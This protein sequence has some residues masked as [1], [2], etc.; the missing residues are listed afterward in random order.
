VLIWGDDPKTR[1][2]EP[3]PGAFEAPATRSSA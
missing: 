3:L 2:I 1:R